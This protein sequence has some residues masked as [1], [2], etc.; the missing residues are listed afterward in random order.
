MTTS[1]HDAKWW[2]QFT[3]APPE[4]QKAMHSTLKAREILELRTG[5]GIDDDSARAVFEQRLMECEHAEQ[6]IRGALDQDRAD[7]PISE[8]ATAVRQPS[9]AVIPEQKGSPVASG[10]DRF[11]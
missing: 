8:K 3:V 10:A 5:L 2:Q 4:L 9:S 6:R 11:W 7:P 1:G